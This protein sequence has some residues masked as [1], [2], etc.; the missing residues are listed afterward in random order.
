MGN[1]SKGEIYQYIKHQHIETGVDVWVVYNKL[2]EAHFYTSRLCD[3]FDCRSVIR[4]D[5]INQILG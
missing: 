2:G 5:K 1:F 3:I 4:D